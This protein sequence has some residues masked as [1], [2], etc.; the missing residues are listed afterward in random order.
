[1]LRLIAIAAVMFATHDLAASGD[2]QT[3]CGWLE[4]P[5]PA[6]FYLLDGEAQWTIA[7][8]GRYR[9]EGSDDIPDLSGQE[10]VETNGPYGYAC[11]CMTVAVDSEKRQVTSIKKVTKKLLKDCRSDAKLP[12][13]SR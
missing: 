1:M 4:N 8:R 11:V 12:R 6:N 10:F 9:A 2:V 3:R 7:E 5:T 13:M